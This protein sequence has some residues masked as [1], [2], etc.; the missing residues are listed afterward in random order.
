MLDV[1]EHLPD[2]IAALSHALSLLEQDG[3]ILITVPAFMQLWT[4]HDDI[5]QHHVRYT[6]QTFA[7]VAARA[8]FSIRAQRYFFHWGFAAKL[9]VRARERLMPGPA[10]PEQVPPTPVNRALLALSLAEQRLLPA[11][12]FGS[13]LLVVGGHPEGRDR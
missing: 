13:S 2:P 3:S 10:S 8:G 7:P 6:Q 1:L 12:P 11:L 5:N 9:L 4:A